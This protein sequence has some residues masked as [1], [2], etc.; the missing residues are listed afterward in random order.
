MVFEIPVIKIYLHVKFDNTSKKIAYARRSLQLQQK[1]MR[2]TAAK[3]GKRR[4][5]ILC[6]SSST[7]TNIQEA[8]SQFLQRST[9]IGI[10]DDPTPKSNPLYLLNPVPAVPQP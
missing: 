1:A 2:T 7:Y 9:I 3:R 8:M 10:G 5:A 6:F 4:D